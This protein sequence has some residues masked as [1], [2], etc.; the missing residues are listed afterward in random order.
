MKEAVEERGWRASISSRVGFGAVIPREQSLAS[1]WGHVRGPQQ[2]LPVQ[3]RRPGAA[4]VGPSRYGGGPL[5]SALTMLPA[6]DG[7]RVWAVAARDEASVIR[8]YDEY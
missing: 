7:T 5:G 8:L 3:L 6:H 1:R 4:L 2:W